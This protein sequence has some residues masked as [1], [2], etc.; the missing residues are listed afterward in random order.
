M[1]YKTTVPEKST[2]K[3][4]KLLSYENWEDVFVKKDVNTLFN[5]FLNTYLRIFYACFPIR[6]ETKHRNCKPLL[7]TGIRI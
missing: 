2:L 6:K 3:F 4:T 1:K 5:N 7:T